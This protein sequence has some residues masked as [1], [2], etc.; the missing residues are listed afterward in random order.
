MISEELSKKVLTIGCAYNPP[1]GGIA[2]VL[3]NY[4]RL[5]FRK[6]Q[7]V[8]NSCEGGFITKLLVLITSLSKVFFLLLFKK[9]IQI[10]HIHTASYNSF[11][12]ATLFVSFA[13]IFKR[14]VVL[15]IH[16]GLFKKYY[17]SNPDKI[18]KT[19][20]RCDCI[21]AMS[22]FWKEWFDG[23]NIAPRIV[24]LE[25]V[26][27]KPSIVRWE[28]SDSRFCLLFLGLITEAKGIYDLVNV[29][30][31]HRESLDGRLW[32][33]IGGN[34]ESD[35]LEKIIEDN[36]LSGLIT[37]EGWADEK[38][39]QQLFSSSDAFILPS[40]FEGLPMSI[41]EAMSYSLPII[42]TTVGGIPEVV[43]ENGILVKPGDTDALYAAICSLMEHKESCDKM[44][45]CSLKR[46]EA[47][48]P[49]NVSKKLSETY[50]TLLGH[51]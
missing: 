14:K 8:A 44:G 21:V 6:F 5:M 19:L 27:P 39:K 10:V 30:N 32:L 50:C 7:F 25:N 22:C 41:L 36:N 33:R 2:Q 24:V 47:H 15:H 4:E 28:K 34:G 9:D 46:V 26:I 42:S 18:R 17:D 43:S 48:Y 51:I 45:H 1:K 38:K 29:I 37:Y 3:Y 20:D 40:Y 49:E 13:K 31:S 12:R 35:N 16:G 23:L 11:K